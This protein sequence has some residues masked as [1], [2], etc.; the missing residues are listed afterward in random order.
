MLIHS[1]LFR[2]IRD[3]DDPFEQFEAGSG[4]VTIFPLLDLR[5]RLEA[6]ILPPKRTECF[7]ETKE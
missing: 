5:D 1:S 4:E 3:I 7:A 2:L 6:S